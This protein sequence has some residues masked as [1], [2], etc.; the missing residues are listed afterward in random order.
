MSLQAIGKFIGPNEI[1]A[2]VVTEYKAN[3]GGEV[4]EVEFKTGRKRLYPLK[5]LNLIITDEVSDVNSVSEK[6]L[7]PALQ[8]VM[9]IV[10]EYN[11]EYGEIEL[12]TK[13]LVTNLDNNFNR[14]LSY[15]WFNDTKEFVPG[16]DPMW[17][18]STTMVEKFIQ[19]S[20][21]N[22]Q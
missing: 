5:V 10:H 11:I 12:F 19:D 18:V 20:K 7:L 2:T 8:K 22:E 9:E 3:D 1:V 6:K 17:Y 16:V 15:L 21:K 13:Q 4:V 14:A